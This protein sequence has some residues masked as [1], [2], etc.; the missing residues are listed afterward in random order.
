VSPTLNVLG[1]E[2]PRAGLAFYIV[3]AVHVPTGL[4]AVTTGAAAALLRKGSR[5][6]MRF[7]RLYFWAICVVFAT[8]AILAAIRWR[9]D[10]HLFLIGAAAFAAACIGRLSRDRHRPGHAPHILGMS[11]SY[12]LMLAAFYIDNGPQLPIWS[13]LPHVAYW[14]LPAVIGG[15]LTWN[16]WRRAHGACGGSNPSTGSAGDET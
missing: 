5:W 10:Y 13:R 11:I 3:L 16:A 8:A 15:P 14:L 1:L 2:L 6:H 9:E 7:G 12:I 4:V